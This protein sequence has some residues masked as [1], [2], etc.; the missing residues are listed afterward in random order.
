MTDQTD[1]EIDVAAHAAKYSFVEMA[2]EALPKLL[3]IE[4]PVTRELA[5]GFLFDEVYSRGKRAQAKVDRETLKRIV[6]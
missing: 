2:Q 4:D 1:L 6:G 5:L 3:A